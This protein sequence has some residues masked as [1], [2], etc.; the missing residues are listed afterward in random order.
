MDFY[1]INGEALNGSPILPI[2]A[3]ADITCTVDVGAVATRVV[4]PSANLNSGSAAF[5]AT[6]THT[7]AAQTTVDLY[8]L[9]QSNVTFIQ[10]ASADI[11]GSADII[12][13][14]YRIVPCAVQM[15]CYADF[16]A[17]PA[18]TLAHADV[19]GSITLAADA[20]KIQPGTAA[21]PMTVS[22]DATPTVTRNVAAS[23]TGTAA[24]RV[25]AQV[26]NHLD[27]F[28]DIGL[29]IS[30]TSPDTG[31]VLRQAAAYV[32]L[33]DSFS[34]VPTY[35]HESTSALMD[36]YA[37][38]EPGGITLAVPA[39]IISP[40]IDFT[41]DGAR[42]V[43]PAAD[44]PVTADVTA[45]LLQIHAGAA[46][47]V[48]SIDLVLTPTL[49]QMPSVTLGAS[50]DMA[51]SGVA[52]RMAAADLQA[53]VDVA[54]GAINTMVGAAQFVD[55]ST[56]LLAAPT[57]I[58]LATIDGTVTADFLAMSSALRPAAA[59][60]DVGAALDNTP[61]VTRFGSA[62]LGVSV[63]FAANPVAKIMAACILGVTVDLA[64]NARV[65]I[66][67]VDLL[68]DTMYRPAEDTEF[69]RP[70]EDIEMRRYA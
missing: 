22:V 25:E 68:D 23:I 43:L 12:A 57:R 31:I 37:D 20:T 7:Q 24:L 32:E 18:S 59:S 3:S 56:T 63:N 45:S 66:E 19:T 21:L 16:Q 9:I 36:C 67:A 8:A 65:N 41:A 54:P 5:T 30:F 38:V 33:L 35:V 55:P 29:S 69:T 49:T 52:M 47:P 64:V 4:L 6:S 14:V 58:C 60:I 34:I 27:G 53:S 28:A 17:I 13:A 2:A 15:D 39:S 40:T 1:A 62:D 51:A 11:T 44:M 48:G 46:T 26:N 10:A 50:I 42:Y 70:F 61:V